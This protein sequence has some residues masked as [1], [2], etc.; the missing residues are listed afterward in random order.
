MKINLHSTKNWLNKFGKKCSKNFANLAN[1][2]NLDSM[3]AF[4]SCRS[5]SQDSPSSLVSFHFV[6]FSI[7]HILNLCKLF[8]TLR[9]ILINRQVAELKKEKGQYYFRNLCSLHGTPEVRQ[10][11]QIFRAI[12]YRIWTKNFFR[13]I[14]LCIG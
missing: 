10:V 11:S 7:Y 2:Y 3:Q 1:V 8:C 6:L 14:F 5:A 9:K 13:S 4:V 12:L